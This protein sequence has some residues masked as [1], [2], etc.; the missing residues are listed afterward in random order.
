MFWLFCRSGLLW[1]SSKYLNVIINDFTCAITRFPLP[2]TDLW[3]W[4][5][6]VWITCHM[7]HMFSDTWYYYYLLRV[8]WNQRFSTRR[9]DLLLFYTY[10]AD[11]THVILVIG[12]SDFTLFLLRYFDVGY[13]EGQV[14]FFY[15]IKAREKAHRGLKRWVSASWRHPTSSTRS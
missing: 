13:R 3:F 1:W 9:K 8:L 11:W 12:N 10:S 14:L 4:I 15:T 6:S 5:D 7:Y 2:V